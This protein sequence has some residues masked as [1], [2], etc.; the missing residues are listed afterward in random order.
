[1]GSPGRWR[2][3]WDFRWFKPGSNVV[4]GSSTHRVDIYDQRI[5]LKVRA[6]TA[7]NACRA[8]LAGQPAVKVGH[9]SLDSSEVALTF[10]FGSTGAHPRE[11]VTWLVDNRVPATV[12][13]VGVAGETKIGGRV[14]A[15][16]AAHR[17][18]I[19]IGNHSFDHPDFTTQNSEQVKEQL[20]KAEKVVAPRA[21]EPRNPYCV[22]RLDDQTLTRSSQSGLP[23][24]HCWCGGT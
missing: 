15:M 7:T 14:L 6:G 9:G 5:G 19:D 24:G 8:T 20:T 22:R 4:T 17:D 16:I 2:V 21:V 10:D 1:M 18:L 11:I 3:E 23:D 12:F 13:A